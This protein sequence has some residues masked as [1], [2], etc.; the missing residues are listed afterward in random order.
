LISQ[1]VEQ[2]FDAL[3]KHPVRI[4]SP[5]HPVPTSH[6]MTGH[7]Y[8]GSQTIADAVLDLLDADK[9]SPAY[10]ALRTSLLRNGPHDIPNRSFTGPF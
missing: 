6:F 2:D 10:K 1:V 4:A 8:P 9:D 5:D 3:K 7:Y